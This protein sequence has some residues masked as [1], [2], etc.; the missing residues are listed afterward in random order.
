MDDTNW[1]F[2]HKRQHVD[3]LPSEPKFVRVYGSTVE[4]KTES[5]T[6][7]GKYWTQKIRWP[8]FQVLKVRNRL[9]DTREAIEL[10]IE[11]GDIHVSCNCPSFL[12]HGWKYEATQYDFNYGRGESRFPEIRNPKLIDNKCKHLLVV[13]QAIKDNKEF[14]I[15]KFFTLYKPQ[16]H[17]ETV[18]PK[19]EPHGGEVDEQGEVEA[20]EKEGWV[21]NP[22]GSV[23]RPFDYEAPERVTE[24]EPELPSMEEVERNRRGYWEREDEEDD[25]TQGRMMRVKQ[26]LTSGQRE[27]FRVRNKDLMEIYEQLS[28]SE[29][30]DECI[31][32][33][34]V[35]SN[36]GVKSVGDELPPSAD[37]EVGTGDF[38]GDF[39]DGASA[40][41]VHAVPHGAHEEYYG[42]C[43]YVVEGTNYSYGN[44]RGEVVLANPVVKK[45]FVKNEE[46]NWVMQH[47]INRTVTNGMKLRDWVKTLY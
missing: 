37:L 43:V 31:G 20:V 42:D 1:N 18:Q 30:D 34:I 35:D 44:D 38:T 10:A 6:T 19:D 5:G 22:D 36:D 8:D 32:L 15:D 26:L 21:Q 7:S 40:V 28:E 27:T 25:I 4:Y 46:G 2:Y 41:G 17:K 13:L 45:I 12:Y 24:W 3:E 39:L 47:R 14:L 16:I 9:T 33:R 23:E 29:Q 11:A